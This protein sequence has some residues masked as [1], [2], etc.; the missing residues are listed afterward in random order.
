MRQKFTV[1]E[2]LKEFKLHDKVIIGVNPSATG[3]FPPA[4]YIG[5]VGTIVAKRGKSYIVAMRDG[6]KEKQLILRPEHLK[7]HK[8]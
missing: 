2:L 3:G 5:L 8:A 7:M 1:E 4:R 6:N